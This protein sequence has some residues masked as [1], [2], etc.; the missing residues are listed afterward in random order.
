MVAY[1]ARQTIDK[2]KYPVIAVSLAIVVALPFLEKGEELQLVEEVSEQ[3]RFDGYSM[4]YVDHMYVNLCLGKP[5][6]GSD[7]N[8][9]RAV[10]DAKPGDLALWDNHYGIR[11]TPLDTFANGWVVVWREQRG[12]FRA[13]LFRKQ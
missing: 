10:R 2:Y 8:V 3:I 4:L 13:A 7:T 6:Y 12:D 1:F 9:L 5:L 11:N